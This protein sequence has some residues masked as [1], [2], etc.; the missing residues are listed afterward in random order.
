MILINLHATKNE[1]NKTNSP[2]HSAAYPLLNAGADVSL[3]HQ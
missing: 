1:N 3:Q 2:G